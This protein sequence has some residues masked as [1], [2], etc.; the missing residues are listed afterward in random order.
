MDEFA[1]VGLDLVLDPIYHGSMG[2]Q[3]E[4]CLTGLEL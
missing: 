1:I 2:V 3:K 4:R